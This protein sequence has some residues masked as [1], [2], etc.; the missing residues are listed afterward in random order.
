MHRDVYYTVQDCKDLIIC[1]KALLKL[2]I[3]VPK[4]MSKKVQSNAVSSSFEQSIIQE[5]LARMNSYEEYGKGWV[6]K[7]K[8]RKSNTD[9]FICQIWCIYSVVRANSS[10]IRSPNGLKWSVL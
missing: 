3:F 4:R 6:G 2:N 9:V 10:Q 1:F 8:A 5:R 7:S